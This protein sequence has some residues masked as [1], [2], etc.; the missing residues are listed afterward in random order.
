MVILLVLES[1]RH[2]YTEQ[3]SD[4]NIVPTLPSSFPYWFLGTFVRS[5]CLDAFARLPFYHPSIHIAMHLYIC[6][7]VDYT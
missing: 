4:N 3:S 7:S 2:Q 5:F 6:Q 1:L